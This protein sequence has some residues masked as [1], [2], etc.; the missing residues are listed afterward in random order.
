MCLRCGGIFNDCLINMFTAESDGE[1]IWKI[2]QH[3][4]KLWATAGRP[5]FFDSRVYHSRMLVR[6]I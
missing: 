2:G 3:L 4:S 6:I 1:R 5:L